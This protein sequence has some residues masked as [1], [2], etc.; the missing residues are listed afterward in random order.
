MLVVDTVVGNVHSDEH[1]ALSIQRKEK[2]GSALRVRISAADAQRRRL[3]LSTETG[4]DVGVDIGRGS[5]LQDGDVLCRQTDTEQLVVV[6]VAPTEAM[7]IRLS[8]DVPADELFA[9]GVRVGHMLGNQHWPVQV[10]KDV[11]LTPVSIDRKVMET[12]V[13]THGFAGLTWEFI[14]V[15]S[16]RVPSAMPRIEHHHG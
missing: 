4:I 13:A 7:A 5:A 1:L 14:P 15:K 2:D 8:G 10:E 11:V 16:G 3:R 9:Y 6:D 12:V